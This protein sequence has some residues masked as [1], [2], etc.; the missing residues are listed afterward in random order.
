MG[1]TEPDRA[2]LRLDKPPSIGGDLHYLPARVG[3]IEVKPAV[4]RRDANVGLLLF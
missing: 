1:A 3:E 4:V 2:L